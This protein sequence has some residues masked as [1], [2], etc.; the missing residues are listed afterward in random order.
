M[1]RKRQREDLAEA[2]RTTAK[3]NADKA[4]LE[5]EARAKSEKLAADAAEMR[6]T[7]DAE[8]QRALN[9]AKN[10]LSD[11]Q[12]SMQVKMAI[13]EHLPA[14]I[15]ESVKPMEQIDGIKIIQVDGISGGNSG[16]ASNGGATADASGNLADQ[17]VSSALKYRA[18]APLI[19]S[20]MK[21]VGLQGRDLNGLTNA[22]GDIASQTPED[23]PGN[24]EES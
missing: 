2:A 20:L 17:V 9:D 18:Q 1:P 16:G 21:E 14:I 6:Y 12:I 8:G 13:V 10:L 15:R 22:L 3:G 4:I 5:A 23:I 11:S 19:E 7:V 24:A